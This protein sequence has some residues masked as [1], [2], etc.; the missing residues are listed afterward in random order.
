MNAREL[1]IGNLVKCKVSNDARIY[2]VAAL[3]GMHCKIMLSD[4]RFGTW[5]GDDKIKP[6]PLTEEL[7][8]KCGFAKISSKYEDDFYAGKILLSND[9]VLSTSDQCYESV[10]VDFAKPLKYLH[11]LQN[12]TFTLTGEELEVKI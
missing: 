11:Q 5:Y 7:L 2:S 12:L 1:R 9:F 6:I 8:L 10:P 4:V 3:D